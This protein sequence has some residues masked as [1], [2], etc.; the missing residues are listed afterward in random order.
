MSRSCTFHHYHLVNL[1]EMLTEIQ[2]AVCTGPILLDG[3]TFFNATNRVSLTAPHA[4]TNH[5]SQTKH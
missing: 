1:D 5:K 4:H 3:V 2:Q